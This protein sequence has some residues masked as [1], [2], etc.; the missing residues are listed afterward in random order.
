MTSRPT[1]SAAVSFSGWPNRSFVLTDIEAC[2]GDGGKRRRVLDAISTKMQN[3]AVVF[4]LSSV[5]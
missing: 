2:I 3:H 1:T 4:Y 5:R